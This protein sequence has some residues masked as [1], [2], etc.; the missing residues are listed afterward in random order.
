M[1]YRSQWCNESHQL[2]RYLYEDLNIFNWSLISKELS[3]RL[4]IQ[5]TPD[6]C[7]NKFILEL[8]RYV[9]VFGPVKRGDWIHEEEKELYRL[10][11]ENGNKWAVIAQNILGRYFII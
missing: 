8:F 6:E 2:L 7:R 10:H 5:A 9:E 1:D 4:H 3:E 11:N